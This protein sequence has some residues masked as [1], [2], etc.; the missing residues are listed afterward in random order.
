MYLYEGPQQPL[1]TLLL[2]HGAG[3]PMDS[4]FLDGIAAGLAAAGIGT[5]RFEFPYMAQ[6]RAGGGKR[7]P[8]REPRLLACWR[9][10]IEDHLDRRPLFIGGK[11]MGG[12]MASL[13][14]REE[15]PLAGVV[16]LG[17]PF[18]PPGKPER[19]RLDHWPE[20]KYPALILQGERDPFGN[21]SE[22]EGYVLPDGVSLVW[23]PEGDHDL[24]PPKRSPHS[25][26][27]NLEQAIGAI[28]GF[29]RAHA[30]VSAA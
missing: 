19:T 16:C 23:I 18:H 20:V 12:R 30:G 7:P 6:R 25:V 22:V 11:S 14:A 4:P 8:D 17:F 26:Q 3:T 13:V 29:I 28:A 1:A 27:G 9:Q 2:A 24:A 21:R 10:V 5:V 15:W